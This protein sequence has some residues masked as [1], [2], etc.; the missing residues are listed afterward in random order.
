M[1]NNYL[2]WIKDNWQKSAVLILIYV[3]ATIIPLYSRINLIEFMFLLAFP[4]YLVHEIEEY[5]LP[6]GFVRFFNEN[7]LKVDSH[8]KILPIDREVVFW[9][10]MIY[11]WLVIPIFS[12]LGVINISFAAW[13]PYFF[14]FQALSHLV[15]GIKGKMIINPGIRSS[16]ILHTPYAIIMIYLLKNNG[17]ISNPY[18]N[19]YMV[20]GFLFNGLLPL[21]AKFIILPRYNKL[22]K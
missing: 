9:I 6:G 4:L 13:I 18:L 11:I 22:L 16:F 2:E 7:L 12:G 20:I 8:E 14:L 3:L 19:M 15:M 17:V 21:M 1:I 5:I 10:N